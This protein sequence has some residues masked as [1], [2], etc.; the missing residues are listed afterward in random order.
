[1]TTLLWHEKTPVH[2]QV[3]HELT[4]SN[5]GCNMDIRKPSKLFSQ[6]LWQ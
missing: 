4:R 5:I 3:E 1:M 2:P 6:I